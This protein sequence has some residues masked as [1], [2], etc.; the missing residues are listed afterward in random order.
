M[1][2]RV[3]LSAYIFLHINTCCGVNKRF[4]VLVTVLLKT[5]ILLDLILHLWGEEILKFRKIPPPALLGLIDPFEKSALP[6]TH[7]LVAEDF[8]VHFKNTAFCQYFHIKNYLKPANRLFFVMD[9][10][11][12]FCDVGIS[13]T[14]NV[15]W[16]R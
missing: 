2:V 7:R 14:K 8:H 13:W 10:W 6:N 3:P 5:E 11:R 15:V 16:T 4:E 12:V 9:K 1:L